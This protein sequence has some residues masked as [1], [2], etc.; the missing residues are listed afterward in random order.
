MR[1]NP[2]E[3]MRWRPGRASVLSFWTVRPASFPPR[4]AAGLYPKNA[5]QEGTVSWTWK[6][7]TRTTPGRWRIVV[8]AEKDG[9]RAS[10]ATYFT[11]Y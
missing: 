1:Q 3:V 9:S 8:T 6:V 5:D 10:A 11:V 7:D 4:E 2:Q